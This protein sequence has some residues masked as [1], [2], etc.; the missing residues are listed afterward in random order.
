MSEQLQI[1][2]RTIK[3][4]NAVA[5]GDYNATLLV[6]REEVEYKCSVSLLRY[7]SGALYQITEA[8]PSCLSF[9]IL[10]DKSATD[11]AFIENLLRGDYFDVTKQIWDRLYE[12]SYELRSDILSH[13]VIQA[14]NQGEIT[15]ENCISRVLLKS[16]NGV[17]FSD[18]IAFIAFHFTELGAAVLHVSA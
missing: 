5:F 4:L 18:E 7:L 15:I 16:T 2:L 13:V 3:R 10:K 17:D 11:F 8:D 9:H 1:L 12:L 6:G 14:M